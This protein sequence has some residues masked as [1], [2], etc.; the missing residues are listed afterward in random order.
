[1]KFAMFSKCGE[2]AQVLYRIACE[3]NDVRLHIK[4]K[5]YRRN[6]DGLVPKVNEVNSFIDH[7]T[8]I[9]FDF[10]GMGDLADD[11]RKSGYKVFGASSFADK[12]EED[13]AFGLEFMDKCGI[14]FPATRE[15]DVD[16][17]EEAK[18]Y[19]ASREAKLAFKPSGES[20][21]CHLTYCAEDEEDLIR[22]IDYVYQYFGKDIESFVLQ[23]FVEG[24]II[25][26][27]LFFD[28]KKACYPANHTIEAKKFL[29]GDLGPSVGCSGNLVW[30]EFNDCYIVQEGIGRVEDEL[31]KEQFCGQLDL[32]AIVNEKGTFG[33]EWTPRFGYDSIPS[34][35]PLIEGDVA[36]FFYK[37][38]TGNGRMKLKDGFSAGVRFTIPPYPIEPEHLKPILKESP[39]LGVPIRGFDVND[40]C[41]LYFFEIMLDDQDSIVHGDGTGVLGVAGGIADESKE[42][43]TAAYE[44]LER[45]KVPDLQYRNDLGKVIPKMYNEIEQWEMENA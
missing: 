23:D 24:D 16:D 10:S 18:K 40:I 13:R 38:A 28:G 32:N 14:K 21:P 3:G 19:I 2:G 31:I 41:N 22:Y 25:S 7:D 42:A 35:L 15:F 20:L 44:L 5:E 6:W 36:E 33:L 11:L 12:L 8:I 30:A 34:L 39:N 26:S 43:F 9:L 1:M 29:A 45:A 27:E 37:M 4:E 17:L